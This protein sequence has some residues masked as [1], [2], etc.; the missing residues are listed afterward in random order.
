MLLGLFAFE[1]DWCN[2]FFLL[3]FGAEVK[4][5]Y[6]TAEQI[7]VPLSRVTVNK[8]FAYVMNTVDVQF[9][10]L[11]VHIQVLQVTD[12]SSEVLAIAVVE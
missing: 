2:L 6:W 3:G 1:A 12:N 4:F 11:V 7:I 9:V 8:S 10:H 5:L